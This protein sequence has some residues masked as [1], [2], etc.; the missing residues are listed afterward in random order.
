MQNNLEKTESHL[1][2]FKP[3]ILVQ[4]NNKR[5][6]ILF[7]DFAISYQRTIIKIDLQFWHKKSPNVVEAF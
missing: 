5:K 7:C 2:F 3:A 4:V 1:F 6:G